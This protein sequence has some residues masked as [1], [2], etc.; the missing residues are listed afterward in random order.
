MQQKDKSELSGPRQR[1]DLCPAP[2]T[3]SP[4]PARAY[5]NLGVVNGSGV[6]DSSPLGTLSPTRA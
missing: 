6:P 2:P 5:T 3:P 1:R 4:T